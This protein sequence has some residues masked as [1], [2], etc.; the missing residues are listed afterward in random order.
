MERIVGC[1]HIIS[2][3]I[4]Q[5]TEKKTRWEAC[6][7]SSENT[8]KIATAKKF[9]QMQIMRLCLREFL[10]SSS[11]YFEKKPTK[12]TRVTH[13][14][15]KQTKPRWSFPI[16][17]IIILSKISECP[18]YNY[19]ILIC[20]NCLGISEDIFVLRQKLRCLF[21]LFDHLQRIH[22]TMLMKRKTRFDLR[23]QFISGMTR[24]WEG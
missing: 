19:L 21:F 23:K 17:I 5:F 22:V 2:S 11:S 14:E 10:L 24:M 6:S 8:K 9:F 12:L 13:C 18:H 7:H 1:V 20:Y 3:L 16:I 15:K 4:L